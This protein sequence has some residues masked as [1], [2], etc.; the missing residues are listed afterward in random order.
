[1]SV[2]LDQLLE[3]SPKLEV[4]RANESVAVAMERMREHDYSQL[5]VV[6]QGGAELRAIGLISTA[7]IARTSL[8]LD[9][10]PTLLRV[11]HALDEHPIKRKLGDDLWRTL[12]QAR[13]GEVLLVEDDDGVLR[14]VLTGQDFTTYLRRQSEDSLTVLDIE[15]AIKQLIL[16]HYRDRDAELR[17]VVKNL[18]GVDQRSLHKT[19][20]GIVARCLTSVSVSPADLDDDMFNELVQKRLPDKSPYEFDRLSFNQYQQVL[21]GDA[22]WAA[23][24]DDFDLPLERLRAL[25]TVAREL[26]NQIMHNR[27]LPTPAERT[28]LVY[29]R[30]LLSRV[31]DRRQEPGAAEASEPQVAQVKQPPPGAAAE[32]DE[33][34]LDEAPGQ[35]REITAWL[36]SVDKDQDRV[37]WNFVGRLPDEARAHRSWWTN[38]EES[39]QSA[40]WLEASWR[41][42]SVNLTERAVTF[43]RNSARAEVCIAIFSGIFRRLAANPDWPLQTPSPAGRSSQV[44]VNIAQDGGQAGLNIGFTTGEQFRIWL[45]INTSD[46]DV[47][48]AS[49]DAL[50]EHRDEL[51][52]SIGASL[53]WERRPH[54][55]GSMVMLYY[56]RS[57]SIRSGEEAIDELAAWVAEYVPRFYAA[58]RARYATAGVEG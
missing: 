51:E 56:P 55:R 57:V 58:M 12:D 16:E 34:D 37:T 1:M 18:L 33:E 28:R 17:E 24:K 5:P 53:A 39:P 7:T 4:A 46:T 10:P 54:R 27:G 30:D 13:D 2:T 43:G 50:I 25:L 31:A 19:V 8:C 38:D 6:A 9:M 49:F 45:H 32:P 42:V 36:N 48:K 44:L 22:C 15:H 23:Y 41:V 20:R 52:R 29:C 14:G 3:D 40:I 47:N 35:P 26:R 21:L 11:H